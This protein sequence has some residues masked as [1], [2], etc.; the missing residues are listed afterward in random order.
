MNAHN[1]PTAQ[2]SGNLKRKKSAITPL[3]LNTVEFQVTT[4]TP[5]LSFLLGSSASLHCGFSMAPGLDLTSVVWRLQ[6]KGS[7]QL[8]A[9]WTSGQEHVRR[10]GITLEPEQQLMAGNA[11][12]TLSSLTLKD[13]GTYICQIT[14]SLFQAQQI[15]QLHVQGEGRTWLSG[16]EGKGY[17]YWKCFPERNP[18]TRAFPERQIAFPQPKR[19]LHPRSTD[20]I[21]LSLSDSMILPQKNH[22]AQDPAAL[23]WLALS[24]LPGPFRPHPKGAA[25][26]QGGAVGVVLTRKIASLMTL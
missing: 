13:E 4:R 26:N 15:I 1:M 18:N 6:Y 24:N 11:S 16:R 21:R 14:T 20:G 5:S 25:A 23:L 9:S 8:V 2:R 12:L 19:H 3:S 10:E 22:P 7:G 17:A